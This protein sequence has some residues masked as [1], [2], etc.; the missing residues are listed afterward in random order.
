MYRPD[1]AMPTEQT[2][3]KLFENSLAAVGWGMGWL[4]AKGPID[5][6]RVKG[7]IEPRHM[8]VRLI[9]AR[10]GHLADIGSVEDLEVELVAL[11]SRLPVASRIRVG[12][13]SN[14]SSCSIGRSISGRP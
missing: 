12:G 8:S 1:T 11:L 6:Y 9:E 14:C 5:R 10:S 4:D 2:L 3:G 13:R 7:A